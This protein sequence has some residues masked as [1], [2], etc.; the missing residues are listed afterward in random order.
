[1]AAMIRKGMKEVQIFPFSK[2]ANCRKK[3]YPNVRFFCTT[4]KMESSVYKTTT[5]GFTLIEILIV[6]SILAIL[7]AAAIP[8]F[9]SY[10]KN[11]I[12]AQA[13]KTVRTDFRTAQNFSISGAD[14]KVWGIHLSTAS[15]TYYIFKCFSGTPNSFLGSRSEYRY[16]PANPA[17]Y[18]DCLL[19]KT[20]EI[21]PA[22]RITS[23][24]VDIAFETVTA[25][26][27]ID[28]IAASGTTDIILDFSVGTPSSPRHICISQSGGI[29]EEVTGC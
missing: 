1:M 22:V 10:N 3:N 9:N 11:Q 6:I 12:L 5:R 26:V 2:I 20:Q 24:D 21:S 7:M 23:S 16:N 17:A 14:G 29:R 4:A 8:T 19:N 13:V 28:G 25:A 18:P 27:Y 15:A